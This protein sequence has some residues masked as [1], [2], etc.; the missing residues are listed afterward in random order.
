MSKRGTN[1]PNGVYSYGAP[2]NGMFTQGDSYFV[3]PYSGSDG[4]DGKNPATAFKTLSAALAATTAN[5]NDVIYMYAESVSTAANTTDYQ[6]AAGL[7]WNKDMVHLIGINAGQRISQRSRIA[8]I[9][10][11]TAGTADLLTVSASGCLFANIEIFNGVANTNAMSAVTITG[12]RN[13][14]VNC[15]IAGVGNTSMDVNGASSLKLSG[16]KE[17]YFED[18]VIG[19]DTISR[20]TSSYVAEIICTSYATRN[21]FKG[22]YIIGLCKTAANYFFLDAGAIHALDRFIIFDNCIFFN[23]GADSAGATMTYAMNLI[24]TA[25][26]RVLLHNSSVTGAADLQN[27]AGIAFSNLP[28]PASATDAG[29]TIANIKT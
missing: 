7:T 13:H 18:C 9:S 25:G 23:A 16:A 1:F 15:Q 6:A 5:Q 14:F 29:L 24:S 22:C 20:G 12:N 10:T 17:N 19:T 2:I 8:F 3:K 4:N 26:G 27:N 21:S 11:N 28:I